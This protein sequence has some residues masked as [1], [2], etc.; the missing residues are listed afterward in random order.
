M[1]ALYLFVD[2]GLENKYQSSLEINPKFTPA[3]VA[4]GAL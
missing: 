3:H 4:V 2:S 1:G